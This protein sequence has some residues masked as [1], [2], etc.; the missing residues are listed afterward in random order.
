[1]RTYVRKALVQWL[2]TRQ[3]GRGTLRTPG[4]SLRMALFATDHHPKGR[5]TS[6]SELIAAAHAGSF[7]LTLANELGEAG[8]SPRRIDASSTVTME[9]LSATGWT[10]TQIHLDV[11]AAVPRVAE[12][13][14]VDATLRAK[15]GCP[16]SRA[17]TANIS[18]SAKLTTSEPP[19]GPKRRRSRAPGKPRSAG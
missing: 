3:H 6:P 5:G 15:A 10:M 7:T 1:M 2:G 14:F 18:L 9:N 11:V 13:E 17:L 8:Y 4:A 16:I 12:C 19:P